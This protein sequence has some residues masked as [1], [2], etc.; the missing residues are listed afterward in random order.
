MLSCTQ[1]ALLVSYSPT[2]GLVVYFCIWYAYV[3]MTVCCI[4]HPV[5]LGHHPSSSTSSTFACSSI[6]NGHECMEVSGQLLWVQRRHH[7]QR[8]LMS[9]CCCRPVL[10]L[11]SS[12]N[13]VEAAAI[14]CSNCSVAARRQQ[15]QCDHI[16]DGSGAGRPLY[17]RGRCVYIT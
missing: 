8:R 6:N 11:H 1:I 7:H 10:L 16:H 4:R 13:S 3:I 17:W 15:D 12:I 14:S 2:A 9:T 5:D